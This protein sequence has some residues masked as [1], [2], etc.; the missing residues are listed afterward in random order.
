MN[1]RTH[2]LISSTNMCMKLAHKSTQTSETSLSQQCQHHV[3]RV[4]CKSAVIDYCNNSTGRFWNVVTGNAASELHILTHQCS[5]SILS[6]ILWGI[7]KFNPCL[8]L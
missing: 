1:L 4:C 2:V 6:Y 5:D 3:Q 8:F 7:L